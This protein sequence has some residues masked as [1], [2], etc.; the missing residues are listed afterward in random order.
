MTLALAH[1]AT[2]VRFCKACACSCAV[3][4]QFRH[5]RPYASISPARRYGRS[6]ERREAIS[7]IPRHAYEN[8]S[9]IRVSYLR[10]L[11]MQRMNPFD[12][13]WEKP[14]EAMRDMGTDVQKWRDKKERRNEE[15]VLICSVFTPSPLSFFDKGRDIGSLAWNAR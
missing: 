14:W 9:G 7:L 15:N 6:T 2:N 8:P 3:F 11:L 10:T 12:K 5:V 13:P 4:L 1:A